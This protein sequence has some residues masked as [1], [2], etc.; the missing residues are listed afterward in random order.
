VVANQAQLL[1]QGINLAEEFQEE[2]TRSKILESKLL[3]NIVKHLA[4][5]KSNSPE[6][7]T[8]LIELFD[9]CDVLAHHQYYY[10]LITHICD[11]VNSAHK[12]YVRFDER[13]ESIPSGLTDETTFVRYAET[14]LPP[15]HNFPLRMAMPGLDNTIMIKAHHP[16][17][18]RDAVLICIHRQRGEAET[19]FSEWAQAIV[20]HFDS[21]KKPWAPNFLEGLDGY[22]SEWATLAR[23][24]YFALVTATPF[25]DPDSP[26]LSILELIQR[27]DKLTSI[28]THEKIRESFEY[29]WGTPE[30]N[31][32]LGKVQE[33]LTMS[34]A[35]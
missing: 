20:A 4:S 12:G 28:M 15:R 17:S 3:C 35:S 19:V 1:K 11:S 29:A 2:M 10:N 9:Q 16:I 7:E 22:A 23:E 25:K 21:C 31:A 14:S 33:I 13:T 26:G 8:Q 6:L 34:C 18:L 5:K 32:A 30:F 27:R 24:I